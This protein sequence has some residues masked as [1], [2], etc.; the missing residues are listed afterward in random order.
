MKL[1]Y[2]TIA[3][4]VLIIVLIVAVALLLGAGDAVRNLLAAIASG[5]RVI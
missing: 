5:M 3:I 1:P 2:K 4:I